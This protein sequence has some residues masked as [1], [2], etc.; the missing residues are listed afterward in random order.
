MVLPSK[1]ILLPDLS[2]ETI[3]SHMNSDTPPAMNQPLC[4]FCWF[5][6]GREDCALEAEVN[7][8][9][10]SSALVMAKLAEAAGRG[11]PKAEGIKKSLHGKEG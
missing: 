10:L 1:L 5:H 7:E 4:F 6:E 8:I 9:N 11:C 3:H 2:L